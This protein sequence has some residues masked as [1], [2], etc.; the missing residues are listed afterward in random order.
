MS[1]AGITPDKIDEVLLV[2][3]SSRMPKVQEVVKA[4]FGKEGNR[5]PMDQIAAN[6]KVQQTI[7]KG[8]PLLRA[9]TSRD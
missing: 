5:S 3:G 6:M 9:R 1:D 4:I 2:G 7:C 8:R